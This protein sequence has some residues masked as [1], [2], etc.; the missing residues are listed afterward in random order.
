MPSAVWGAIFLIIATK[1]SALTV[2]Y[3]LLDAI[4]EAGR[5]LSDF[6]SAE[7]SLQLCNAT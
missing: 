1:I 2:E 7:Q 3:T 4:E 6:L 5:I